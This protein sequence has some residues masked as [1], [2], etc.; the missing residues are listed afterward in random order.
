[1]LPAGNGDSFLITYGEA[2]NPHHVLIDGGPYYA[3]RNKK[4]IKKKRQ[5]RQSNC[6]L[7]S[8]HIF[9]FCCFVL[10]TDSSFCC[11]FFKCLHCLFVFVETFDYIFLSILIL[12]VHE[13]KLAVCIERKIVFFL[14]I[15]LN[16][17][18]SSHDDDHPRGSLPPRG[19]R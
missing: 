15:N 13:R 17:K 3:Y 9:H 18:K 14:L 4:I 7:N 6:I 10:I 19:S 8:F 16:V 1:M 12:D 5:C 2:T 11:A